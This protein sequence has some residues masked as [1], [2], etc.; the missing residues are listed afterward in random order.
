MDKFEKVR[1]ITNFSGSYATVSSIRNFFP[2]SPPRN[3]ALKCDRVCLQGLAYFEFPDRC[4]DRSFQMAFLGDG[5][6]NVVNELWAKSI[7]RFDKR[8]SFINKSWLPALLKIM[9]DA[10]GGAPYFN[11]VLAD[12]NITKDMFS[13]FL[14]NNALSMEL[15]Y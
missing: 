15:R 4:L 5:Q 11:S 10:E 7:S 14:S 3:I 13:K 2:I 6:T 12:A 9:G 1:N 8:L